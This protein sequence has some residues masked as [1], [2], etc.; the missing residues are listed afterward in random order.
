MVFFFSKLKT[1]TNASP[2][3]HHI[4]DVQPRGWYSAQLE[5]VPATQ[6]GTTSLQDVR[7]LGREAAARVLHTYTG[8]Q[9]KL[10]G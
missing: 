3:G 5:W 10:I 2:Q 7:G 6:K 4:C 9:A 8:D 1:S